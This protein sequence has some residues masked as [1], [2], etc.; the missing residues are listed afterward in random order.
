[1]VFVVTLCVFVITS[2]GKRDCYRFRSYITR[3]LFVI[4][5]LLFLMLPLV[6]YVL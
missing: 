1:M 2:M 3:V 4:V 6:R 5:Y